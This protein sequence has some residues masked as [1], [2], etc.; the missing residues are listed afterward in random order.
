[1]SH[2]HH[3]HHDH[4]HHEEAVT[5]M[6]SVHADHS[7]HI[8]GTENM[9]ATSVN[10]ALHHMMSMAVSPWLIQLYKML[11][12]FL[13]V[14]RRLRWEDFI[15]AMAD[16]NLHRTCLVNARHFYHGSFVWRPQVLPRESIL[17]IVQCSAISCGVI[18][19]EERDT[20]E[21]KRACCAVSV[22]LFISIYFDQNMLRLPSQNS[23]F[24]PLKKKFI[25]KHSIP[26]S[27]VG[28]VVHRNP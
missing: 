7:G 9:T 19:W 3:A 18:T 13:V 25:S 20:R 6:S 23:F 16:Q 10:H 15:R 21:W 4:A 17:E 1:M 11:T 5:T 26:F 8:H 22:L 28:E 12:C 2:D 27:M 14:P 24:S